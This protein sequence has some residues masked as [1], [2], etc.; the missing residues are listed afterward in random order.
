MIRKRIPI[1]NSLRTL[2]IG[3]LFWLW[4]FLL[5]LVGLLLYVLLP[6]TES[7][8]YWAEG[9]VVFSLLFLYYF[10]RK[11]VKPLQTIG[12]AMDLLNEQDFSSRLAPVG[13]REA[14]R[15]V[16]LFNRLMDQLKNERLHVREQNHFLYLLISASPMGVILFDFNLR[17]TG[18]NAAALRFLGGL[19]WKSKR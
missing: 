2:R 19:G 17:V 11:A 8:F 4:A 18:L 5:V 9:M 1:P 14:D 13:Q 12:N 3:W 6:V 15:I 16:Q 10:Y 7:A